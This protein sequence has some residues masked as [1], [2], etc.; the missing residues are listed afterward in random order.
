M[1]TNLQTQITK[2]QQALADLESQ[3][4]D[5]SLDFT[6]QK[7]ELQQRL[8]LLQ[9]NVGVQLAEGSAVGGD[10]SSG[11]K[12]TIGNNSPVVKAGEGATV[13]IESNPTT[14]N[15]P[16][17]NIKGDV[18]GSVLSGRFDASVNVGDINVSDIG[19]I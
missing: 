13:N 3:E 7:L 6:V 19:E 15:G 12:I 14:V 1:S 5:L 18:T 17:T 2:L 16:Q 11:D 4:R 9:Q 8:T 10:V